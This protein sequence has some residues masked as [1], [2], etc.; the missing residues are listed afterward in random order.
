MLAKLPAGQSFLTSYRFSTSVHSPCPV[1]F[2][3]VSLEV[4]QWLCIWNCK[5]E[6]E[7]GVHC[8]IHQRS[9]EFGMFWVSSH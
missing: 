7:T 8:T 4:R 5:T 2:T 1:S 3:E 9:F 6:W